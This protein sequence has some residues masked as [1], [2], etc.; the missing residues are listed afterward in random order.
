MRTD[1]AVGE[2][3]TK[4][5]I[6]FG[7]EGDPDPVILR[8]ETQA[9][10]E[11]QETVGAKKV[12][13]LRGRHIRLQ[14]WQKVDPP[15]KEMISLTLPYPPSVNNLFANANNGRRIKTERYLDYIADVEHICLV[16]RVRPIAGEIIFT[17]RA[18]RPRKSGD[19]DNL[20]KAI[21]DSLKGSAFHDDKQIVE[22]HAFRFEDKSN[23]RVEVEITQR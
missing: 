3:I 5:F 2:L 21:L 9:R 18:F 23:P 7:G 22:L 11:F 6:L 16:Q 19:L 17:L 14:L 1:R 15:N 12:P 8:H 20:P 4:A 13:Q 10:S